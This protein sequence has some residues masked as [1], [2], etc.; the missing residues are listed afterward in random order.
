MRTG[1]ARIRSRDVIRKD[2]AAYPKS[3]VL[4]TQST[5]RAS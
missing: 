2:D 1:H 3:S 5:V 4:L